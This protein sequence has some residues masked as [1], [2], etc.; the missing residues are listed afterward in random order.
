MRSNVLTPP[1]FQVVFDSL[2]TSIICKERR[3]RRGLA[4][5]T[6]R[7]DKRR[8]TQCILEKSV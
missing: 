5:V 6:D 8:L 7:A 1:T 2:T 3:G 4:Q